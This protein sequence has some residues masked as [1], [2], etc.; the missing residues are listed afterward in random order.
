MTKT[1]WFWLLA[2]VVIVAGIFIWMTHSA[3]VAPTQQTG[4]DA[5]QTTGPAPMTATVA[6]DGNSFT[7]AS[8]TIAQGGTVNF[9][10]SSGTMWVASDPHPVHDGYDGTTQ[11]VH[12]APGYTG[13]APFDQCSAGGSFSFTFTKTGSW[14]YHDHRNESA[15]GTVVVVAQ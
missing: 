4:T 6:Y 13:P 15:G 3:S 5:T 10:D 12:C 11:Q 7:P 14:G 1:G 9:V 8:V 2:A